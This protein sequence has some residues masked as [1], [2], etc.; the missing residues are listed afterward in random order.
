MNGDDNMKFYLATLYK[1]N[2]PMSETVIYTKN[3]KNT[4]VT[5]W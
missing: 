3:H 4:D 5:A 2:E 1:L